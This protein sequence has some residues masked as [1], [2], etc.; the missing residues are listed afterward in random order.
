LQALFGE[1]FLL[2]EDGSKV[3][4]PL[5]KLSG[6]AVNAAAKKAV[7]GYSLAK[8]GAEATSRIVFC[9]IERGRTLDFGTGPGPMAALALHDDGEQVLMRRDEFGFGNLDR[10]E[11]WSLEGRVVVTSRV[12]TPYED[13]RGG[14]RDV[15]WAEF[16]Q[17]PSGGQGTGS[18]QTLGSSRVTATGLE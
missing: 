18:K 12:W 5:E 3:T 2:R 14:A 7:V 8:H 13:F 1:V 9:D 11:V 17:K 6:M 15:M 16:V 10:L 4:I